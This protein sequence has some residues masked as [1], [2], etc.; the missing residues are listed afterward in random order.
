VQ[1]GD[2]ENPSNGE[3]WLSNIGSAMLRNESVTLPQVKDDSKSTE[4]S[5]QSMLELEVC[6][7]LGKPF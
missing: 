5:N 6:K 1:I 3:T 7:A 4:N 2:E